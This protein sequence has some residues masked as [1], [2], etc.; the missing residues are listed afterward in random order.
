MAILNTDTYQKKLLA[1]GNSVVLHDVSLRRSGAAKLHELGDIFVDQNGWKYVYSQAS[2][3]VAANNIL[4]PTAGVLAE[5]VLAGAGGTAATGAHYKD[6]WYNGNQQIYDAA[7]G[8]T[9]GAYIGY[10][11]WCN[12]SGDATEKGFVTF[13]VENNDTDTLYCKYAQQVT[14]DSAG[15]DIDVTFFHPSVVKQAVV[16]TL[17][18]HVGVSLT[19][20][21]T[22]H[23]FWRQVTGMAW[24]LNDSA[25]TAGGYATTTGDTTAGQVDMVDAADT[26]DVVSIAG[27]YTEGVVAVNDTLAFVKLIGMD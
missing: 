19:A 1:E 25:G 22:T 17:G 6:I 5:D 13:E 3:T 2:G 12:D 20:V 26:M 11:G 15:G 14:L 10:H 7:A 21:T 27:T 4:V 23:Y 9:P 16:N 24:I 8:W 18:T